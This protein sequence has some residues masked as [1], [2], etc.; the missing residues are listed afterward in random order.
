LLAIASS[1]MLET[2]MTH[3]DSPPT[4][5]GA[6]GFWA[7]AFAFTTAMAFTTVPT[8]LWSLY[9][10]RDSFSSFTVTIVF[11][12]YAVAVALSLF[13]VGHLSDW[14]GRRRVLLP[15]LALELLAG[16]VFVTWSSLPGLVLAR[17]LSGFG[18]GAVTATAAGWLP[19][20][21]G[22]RRPPNVATA[23]NLGGLGL[24][25]LVSCV[26]AEWAGDAL[27]VPFLV[28]IAALA[29]AWISLWAVPETHPRPPSLPRYRPQRVIGAG[30]V[31]RPLL[32]SCRRG[33][34]HL[35]GLRSPDLAGAELLGGSPA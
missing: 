7:L 9:A 32:R 12:V 18:V 1:A 21:R 29:L 34:D 5:R 16:L 15:A 3:S 14:Y 13:L 8:P 20:L 28:F 2:A 17:A 23:A 26:L 35:L 27:I 19:E 33:G 22:G 31:A 25:A 4:K 24:G 11:A 10:Q 30:G 6:F